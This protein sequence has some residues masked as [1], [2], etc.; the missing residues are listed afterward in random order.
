MLKAR[1]VTGFQASAMPSSSSFTTES[2]TFCSISESGRLTDA[3][4]PVPPSMRSISANAMAGLISS[5]PSS[6]NGAMPSA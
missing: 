5:A 6:S 1:L 2:T 3:G 4:S